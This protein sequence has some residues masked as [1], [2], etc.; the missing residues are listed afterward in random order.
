MGAVL[1]I[2]SYRIIVSDDYCLFG[3]EKARDRTVHNLFNRG[4]HLVSANHY[5]F[6]G[7]VRSLNGVG[8]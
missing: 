5:R 7:L 1:R 6:L 4:R 3:L 8:Q 2:G